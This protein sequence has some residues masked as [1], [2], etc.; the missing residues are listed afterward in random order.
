MFAG[1]N[2]ADIS[3]YVKRRAH[4]HERLT[5]RSIAFTGWRAGALNFGPIYFE[6][7]ADDLGPMLHRGIGK[8]AYVCGRGLAVLSIAPH[9]RR[10]E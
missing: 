4:A 7:S 5:L 3:E 1:H 6:R 9:D 10:S 2:W 8:G